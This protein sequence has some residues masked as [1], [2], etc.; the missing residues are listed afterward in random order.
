MGEHARAADEHGRRRRPRPATT[1]NV[2]AESTSGDPD[3]VVMAGA[4]LDS[5][6]QGPG[7]ND[8]GSGSA[9]LFETAVQMAKV[10]PRNQLRFAWW[11][12]EEAGLVGSTFYVNDLLPT[13]GARR[14]RPVPQLRHGRRRRTTGCS[15]TTATAPGS[16]SSA[17]TAP[18]TSRRCSSSYYAD[19]DIPSRTDRVQW[20]LR[21]P[22][23]HQQRHPRRRP[24]HRRRGRQ[25]RRGGGARGA[26]P[27]ASPT[28]SATT[29]PATT[30]TTSASRRST[31]T[32]TPSPTRCSTTR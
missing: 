20:A 18:T 21:L 25:D 12:A 28:T 5:V 22:G 10:K 26:G 24:V 14:H 2:L 13:A 15:C 7:I 17:R 6:G 11:G 1:Y 4:H 32:P 31:S 23:V 30:S 29:R 9:A 16:A 3:N 8:N 27:R 19:R